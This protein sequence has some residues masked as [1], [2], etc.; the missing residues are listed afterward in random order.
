[1]KYIIVLCLFLFGCSPSLEEQT[2]MEKMK[3]YDQFK[4]EVSECFQTGG[5]AFYHDMIESETQPEHSYC[6]YVPIN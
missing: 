6:V 3:R 1:M 2:R 5:K 4:N